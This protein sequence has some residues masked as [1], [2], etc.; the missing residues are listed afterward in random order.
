MS[1][2]CFAIAKV[3]IF[4]TP[5]LR[6]GLRFPFFFFSWVR[7]VRAAVP[8]RCHDDVMIFTTAGFESLARVTPHLADKKTPPGDF[9]FYS[10][11]SVA[12]TIP[13]QVVILQIPQRKSRVTPATDPKPLKKKAL[14]KGP[15]WYRSLGQARSSSIG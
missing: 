9:Y 2:I 4:C 1:F 6:T 8:E 14:K 13:S 15:L 5:R 7:C 12:F 11:R 3:N 10:W